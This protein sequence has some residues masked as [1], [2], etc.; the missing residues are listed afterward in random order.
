[1]LCFG[2]YISPVLQQTGRKTTEKGEAKTIFT[3]V[4]NVSYLIMKT[5]NQTYTIRIEF[6]EDTY[7]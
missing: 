3:E 7:L 2:M 4:Q 5:K 6:M 1:M